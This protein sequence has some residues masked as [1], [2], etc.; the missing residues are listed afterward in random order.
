MAVTSGLVL[1]LF[2]R[3]TPCDGGVAISFSIIPNPGLNRDAILT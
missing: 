1:G 3:L 2:I